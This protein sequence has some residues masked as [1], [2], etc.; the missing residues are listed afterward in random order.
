MLVNAVLSV[1]I[2]LCSR[3]DTP[4]AR[5]ATAATSTVTVVATLSDSCGYH[6]FSQQ[7]AA[8]TAAAAGAAPLRR[9]RHPPFN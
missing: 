3:Y 6:C 9:Q 5:I 4:C 7:L 2:T 8:L 1:A